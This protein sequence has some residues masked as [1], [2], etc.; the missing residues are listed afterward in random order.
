MKAIRGLLYLVTV[1]FALAGTKSALA[2]W[3]A[4]AERPVSAN[5]VTA[6]ISTPQ[7]PLDLIDIAS[8][9]VSN[10]VSTYDSDANGRDWMQAGWR[11]N[12]EELH[13]QD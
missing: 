11:S 6:L 3:W 1:V 9:G 13:D 7:N 12:K 8:S 10:W 4:G 2:S 5:G